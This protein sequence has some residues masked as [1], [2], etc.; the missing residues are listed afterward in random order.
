MLV[1]FPICFVFFPFFIWSC[2]VLM[3]QKMRCESAVAQG[4]RSDTLS[5]NLNGGKRT[6]ATPHALPPHSP[7]PVWLRTS[8]HPKTSLAPKCTKT[9]QDKICYDKCVEHFF[10]SFSNYWLSVS[11]IKHKKIPPTVQ[12]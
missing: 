8:P 1:I 7:W 12:F 5:S 10:G 4:L 2:S 3:M 6:R 9:P 11:V